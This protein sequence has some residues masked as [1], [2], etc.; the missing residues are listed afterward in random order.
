MPVAVSV[1][2]LIRGGK[3][4]GLSLKYMGAGEVSL[5]ALYPER[6]DELVLIHRAAFAHNVASLPRWDL[7]SLASIFRRHRSCASCTPIV[8]YM[9]Q[10]VGHVLSICTPRTMTRH[11][12]KGRA[13]VY[14]R[15]AGDV[16]LSL[17]RLASRWLAHF[18]RSLEA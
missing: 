4:R 11:R 12:R 3:Q 13:V 10:A 17:L 14:V 8:H 2:F 1:V 7:E 9:Y 16:E 18:R 5:L 6:Q 15:K